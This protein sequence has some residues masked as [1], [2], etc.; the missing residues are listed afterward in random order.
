MG[1]VSSEIADTVE[2]GLKSVAK[3]TI[4]SQITYE[5]VEKEVKAKIKSTGR[6]PKPGTVKS[7]LKTEIQGMEE[8]SS[9][10]IQVSVEAV[11]GSI[12]FYNKFFDN[13]E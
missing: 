13:N 2:E 11:E 10:T 1:M 8:A 9:K 12:E 3:S 4:G 7:L 6:N 5:T